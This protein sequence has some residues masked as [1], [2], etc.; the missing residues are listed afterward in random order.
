[1]YLRQKVH[2]FEDLKVESQRSKEM[3][4]R[5]LN[6]AD[7]GSH[8]PLNKIFWFKCDNISVLVNAFEWDKN[9]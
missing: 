3:R 2:K 9:L 8:E 6:P 1:M 7:S 5:R 4:K